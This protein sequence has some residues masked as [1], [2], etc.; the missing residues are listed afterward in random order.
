MRVVQS[1]TSDYVSCEIQNNSGGFWW[2]SVFSMG[3]GG[4]GKPGS[5]LG[6][7]PE[8]RLNLGLL[9]APKSG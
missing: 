6:P 4:G 2:R 5:P 3:G 9:E 8:T 1:T 7:K